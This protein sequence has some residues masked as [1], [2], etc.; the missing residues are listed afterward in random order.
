MKRIFV[1]LY[2]FV[3]PQ[4]HENIQEHLCTH[5]CTLS[6]SIYILLTFKYPQLVFVSLL[7]HFIDILVGSTFTVLTIFSVGIVSLM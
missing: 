6:V 4:L 1:Y 2:V 5:I 7:W 3:Q